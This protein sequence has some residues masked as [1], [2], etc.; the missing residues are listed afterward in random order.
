MDRLAF[1]PLFV[2]R[3]LNKSGEGWR[4]WQKIGIPNSPAVAGLK[5]LHMLRHFGRGRR[6]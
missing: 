4:C 3:K 6:R 2:S 1:S 5:A